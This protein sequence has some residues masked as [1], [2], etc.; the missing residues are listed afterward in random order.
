M[1]NTDSPR[2]LRPFGEIKRIG[3]YKKDASAG[4]IG[5]GTPVK[6]EADGYIA[7]ADAG[8]TQI[9]GAAAVYSA[10][11]TADT[12]VEVYDHPDQK[13]VIQD[14]ASATLTQAAVGANAD[15]TTESVN[16]TTEFSSCE[17]AADGVT[18][19]TANLRILDIAPT[20]YPGGTVNAAGDNCDWIV[21]INEHA[22]TQTSGV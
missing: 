8:D 11:S 3:V 18:S 15:F 4:A 21:M 17:L 7:P 1:A 20:I 2:G 6:L 22:L 5:I 14:D 9:L 10:A 12:D 13:F 19:S 16:T